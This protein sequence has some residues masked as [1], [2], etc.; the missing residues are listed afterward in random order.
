MDEII[1]YWEFGYVL[2]KYE[3]QPDEWPIED[4]DW[5]VFD[6]GFTKGAIE[7]QRYDDL[8]DYRKQI[9][10]FKHLIAMEL[11][12]RSVATECDHEP[13]ISPESM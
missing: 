9:I 4:A 11:A 13:A 10:P 6:D 3:Q 12:C 1:G 8:S 2:A 7:A 5:L